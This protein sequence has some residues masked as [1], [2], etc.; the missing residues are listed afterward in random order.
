MAYPN[1]TIAKAR[2]LYEMGHSYPE[3]AE[4]LNLST[5]TIDGYR[6]DL[7]EKTGTNSPAG[8]VIYAYENNIIEVELKV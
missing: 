2:K 3:I 4:K 5:H 7:Y 6:K 1:R 8:L